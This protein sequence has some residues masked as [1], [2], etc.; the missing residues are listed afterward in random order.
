MAKILI[1]DDEEQFLESIAKSL[2]VRDFNVISV[3]RGEKAIEAAGI[4][5]NRIGLLID[6][7]VCRDHLEPSAAVAI[8]HMLDLP[9]N[10][11]NFDLSNACLGFL[12]GLLTLAKIL[13]M[14]IGGSMGPLYGKVFK[15]MGKTFSGQEEIDATLF[16]E[17]LLNV[18]S[19]MEGLSPAKV[20]VKTRLGAFYC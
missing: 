19:G 4:D 17:A 16:G 12:D 7:S 18:K 3:N 5:R 2:Q 10:C 14:R 15:T 6:T 9:S 13:M 20:G 11:L 1:V 8:H